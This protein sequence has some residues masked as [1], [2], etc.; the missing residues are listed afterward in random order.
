MTLHILKEF[1]SASAIRKI[2]L[3]G[4]QPGAYTCATLPNMNDQVGESSPGHESFPPTAVCE[5][6]QYEEDCGR[7]FSSVSGC[8]RGM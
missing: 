2:V 8:S 4:I 7:D 6:N 3:T 1:F 5:R